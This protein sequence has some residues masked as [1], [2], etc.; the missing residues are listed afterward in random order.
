[1]T[2]VSYPVHSDLYRLIRQDVG[3]LTAHKLDLS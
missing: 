2:L 3:P 1:M